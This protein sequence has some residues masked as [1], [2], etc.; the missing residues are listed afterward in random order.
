MISGKTTGSSNDQLTS[1]ASRF[2]R[3]W[4]DSTEV[5]GFSKHQRVL[6]ETLLSS[7]RA[8]KWW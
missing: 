8:V 4:S 5:H 1:R 7:W 6:A 2:T 3:A